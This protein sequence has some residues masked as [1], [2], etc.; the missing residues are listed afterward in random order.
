MQ[1]Q[2]ISCNVC[3]LSVCPCLETPLLDWRLLVKECIAI[4]GIPLEIFDFSGLMIF[5]I[6]YFLAS[7]VFAN[8]PTVHSEVVSRGRVC[9]CGCWRSWQ[10][11][12][13]R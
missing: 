5:S 4:I 11:T 9:G 6:L 10:V 3:D 7:F 12:C 8:L 2:T 13:D 1:I